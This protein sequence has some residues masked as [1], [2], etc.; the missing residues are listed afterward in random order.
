MIDLRNTFNPKIN[1]LEL[2]FIPWILSRLYT[3]DI[4]KLSKKDRNRHLTSTRKFQRGVLALIKGGAILPRKGKELGTV[5]EI[6]NE[7]RKKLESSNV[8]TFNYFSEEVL[9]L[10][11]RVGQ[12]IKNLEANETK[13][14]SKFFIS[15]ISLLCFLFSEIS[16]IEKI[17]RLKLLYNKLLKLEEGKVWKAGCRITYSK[18]N[19][20]SASRL[21]TYDIK[22]KSEVLH[23]PRRRCKSTIVKEIIVIANRDNSC[24]GQENE[25]DIERLEKYLMKELR[26]MCLQLNR[27]L[28]DREVRAKSYIEMICM[29][30]HD[31]LVMLAGLHRDNSVLSN[32]MR[33]E[34]FRS[35]ESISYELLADVNL[36]LD[37]NLQV[38]A[39]LL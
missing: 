4:S 15:E 27:K 5:A 34:S 16:S 39:N 35:E 36:R 12:H 9:T 28:K 30:V 33:K 2:N 24:E 8:H 19:E 21:E 25:K 10:Y 38:R 26:G 18:L 22:E 13:G 11:S 20:F 3:N 1:T 31:L 7:E 29:E 14:R 37:F 23:E 32:Y 6:F 17:K